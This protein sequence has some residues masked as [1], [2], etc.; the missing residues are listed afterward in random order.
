MSEDYRLT[1]YDLLNAKL[2]ENKQAVENLVKL[3][4]PRARD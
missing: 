3:D 1:E 2:N 4:H